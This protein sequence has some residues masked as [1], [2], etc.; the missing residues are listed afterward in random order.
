MGRLLGESPSL[1]V[2]YV[3]YGK[4]GISQTVPRPSGAPSLD[5]GRLVR[6]VKEF[7][8]LDR[9]E[10]AGSL[11]ALSQPI[12]FTCRTSRPGSRRIREEGISSVELPTCF[13]CRAS[14]QGSG[15]PVKF[16][17]SVFL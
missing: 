7:G 16:A 14:R 4:K 3:Y 12:C 15:P 5:P 8:P 17:T 9:R 1:Q 10:K 13:T 6:P 2:S 11:P